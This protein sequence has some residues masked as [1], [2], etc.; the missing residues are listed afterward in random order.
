MVL[1]K[2][3]KRRLPATLARSPK[4]AQATYIHTLET[5]E[6]VAGTVGKE[7][8]VVVGTRLINKRL[9][10][11]WSAAATQWSARQ[12]ERIQGAGGAPSPSD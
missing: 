7:L 8:T 12:F 9:T 2:Q 6:R 5:L 1:S 3:E 4:K 10:P 11:E